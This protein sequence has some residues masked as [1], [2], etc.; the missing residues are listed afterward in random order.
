VQI[1]EKDPEEVMDRFEL[2]QLEEAMA[3]GFNPD[4]FVDAP[5]PE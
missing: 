5:R 2:A 3:D 1:P 4:D